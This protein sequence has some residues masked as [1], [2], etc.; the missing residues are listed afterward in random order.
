MT[1]ADVQKND[2][3]LCKWFDEA[4]KVNMHS[5]PSNALRRVSED[6][7]IIGDDE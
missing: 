3:L 1:V 2:F 7:E 5:F 4:S 6:V